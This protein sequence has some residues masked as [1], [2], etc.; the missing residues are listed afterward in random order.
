MKRALPLV[1][2]IVL[3][4]A[5]VA[6]TVERRRPRKGPV[7]EVGYVDYG[8]GQVRYSAEG[9]GPF[10]ASR[11]KT[12]LKL[13]ALNCGPDLTPTITD[14]YS[15]MD[16]DAPYAGEDIDASMKIGDEHYLI[17]RYEHISYDC[18]PKGAAAPVV[19]TTT[20]HEPALIIPQ[21]TSTTTAAV[22]LSSAA[23]A[24][25]SAAAVVPATS[26]TTLVIPEIPR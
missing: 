13:M 6:V 21:A 15:R 22:E 23:V 1:L 17:E 19:S 9:W 18:R 25:S 26:S 10:V 24:A 8:G 20:V 14:E 7:K 11:R 16:A 12:A 3:L 4:S 2:S 5:C